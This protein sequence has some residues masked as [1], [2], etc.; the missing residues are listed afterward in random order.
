M[1]G[2]QIETQTFAV[3]VES[4]PIVHYLKVLIQNLRMLSKFKTF[5]KRKS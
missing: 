1:P 3:R 4:N 5:R 2:T